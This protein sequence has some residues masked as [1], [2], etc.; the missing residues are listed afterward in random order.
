LPRYYPIFLDILDR[1]SVVFGGN[2][3]GER[4]VRYLL[5]CGS[6]VELFS[7][8]SQ[9]TEGLKSLAGTGAI[10]WTKRSYRAGDLAGAWLA[11]VADTSDA[12]RN[13]RVYS[14][15]RERN[16][17]LNTMDV[18]PMCTFIAP[19]LI[20]RH[21]VTVAL[22]TAGTSPAL[23]RK[24]REEMSAP[25]C[26]CLRWADVGPVLAAARKEVRAKKLVT[27]PEVWQDFMTEDWLAM[28]ESAPGQAQKSLVASVATRHCEVCAPLGRCQKHG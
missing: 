10:E 28:A 1:R 26:R 22:S 20:Q 8:A 23:A 4:K 17:V 24:L 9:T 5:E 12:A 11:I 25:G 15:A 3:E 6:K 7:P 16:V 27:C 13:E 14:E 18:T 19:S 21:D 2:H